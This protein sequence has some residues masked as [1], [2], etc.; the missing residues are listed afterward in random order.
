MRFLDVENNELKTL[1]VVAMKLTQLTTLKLAGNPM[2]ELPLELGKLVYLTHI[3]VPANDLGNV[4]RD[5]VQAGGSAIIRY[6]CGINDCATSGLLDLSK[7]NLHVL[8]PS[9]RE[10]RTALTFLKLDDNP[11]ARLPNWLGEM[12][13]LVRVSLSN[14]PLQRLPA[15]LGAIATLEDVAVDGNST[16][17][18]S[19]PV[20]VVA[21]GKAAVLSY[22]RRAYSAVIHRQLDLGGFG[23]TQFPLLALSTPT[24]LTALALNDNQLQEVPEALASITGLVMLSLANNRIMALPPRTFLAMPQLKSLNVGGNPLVR[25]PITLGALSQLEYLDFDASTALVSPPRDITVKSVVA[26]VTYL[27]RAWAGRRSGCLEL[28]GLSLSDLP[29]EVTEWAPYIPPPEGLATEE[30]AG[31]VLAVEKKA[32]T[33]SKKDRDSTPRALADDAPT[34]VQGQGAGGALSSAA[35]DENDQEQD[36]GEGSPQEEEEGREAAYAV[37]DAE[38]RQEQ[39]E[40]RTEAM[41]AEH[42]LAGEDAA[43]DGDRYENEDDDDRD[44]EAEEDIPATA[45]LR[46][47][48]DVGGVEDAEAEAVV[49]ELVSSDEEDLGAAWDDDEAE[50]AEGSALLEENEVP[51]LRPLRKLDLRDNTLA[52]LREEVGRMQSLRAVHLCRNEIKALPD[53]LA[54]LRNLRVLVA[55]DNQISRVPDDLGALAHSLQLLDLQFN[56]LVEFPQAIARLSLLQELNLSH[57][58]LLLVKLEDPSFAAL[59]ALRYLYLDHN[60]LLA[61]SAGVSSLPAEAGVD[62]GGHALSL[63]SLRVL[64]AVDNQVATWPDFTQAKRLHTMRLSKNCLTKIGDSIANLRLLRLLDISNNQLRDIPA[65]LSGAVRLRELM[66]HGNPLDSAP[67]CAKDA[68]TTGIFTFLTA[69]NLAIQSGKA[70]FRGHNLGSIPMQLL[71][72][73]HLH[74]VDLAFNSLSGSIPRYISMLTNLQ[75]LNLADNALTNV[76]IELSHCPKLHTLNLDRNRFKDVVPCICAISQLEVLTMAE[77]DIVTLPPDMANMVSLVMVDLRANEHLS[78][79][80][81]ALLSQNISRLMVYLRTIQSGLIYENMNLSRRGLTDFP[82]DVHCGNG[83]LKT[84]CLAYNEMTSLP[85]SIAELVRLTELDVSNNMLQLLPQSLGAM[86]HLTSLILNDNELLSLPASFVQLSGLT[87]LA[88]E[89]NPLEN[90]PFAFVEQWTGLTQLSIDTEQPVV[91]PEGAVHS[92]TELMPLEVISQGM[93]KCQEYRLRLQRSRAD[94][95][96]DLSVM[97]LSFMPASVL[98]MPLLTRLN[99]TGNALLTIP[100]GITVLVSM[101]DLGLNDNR[102]STLPAPMAALTKLEMLSAMDNRLVSLAPDIGRLSSL[103]TLNLTNNPDLVCPPPE[104]C[105]QGVGDI[106]SFLN[107]ISSGKTTGSIELSGLNLQLLCLPWQDLQSKLQA[108]VLSR[109]QLAAVPLEVD[110]CTNLTALWLD[111]NTLTG[112]PPSFGKLCALKSL[113]LDLNQLAALPSCVC[114][115]TALERLTL[116]N[117]VLRFLHPRMSELQSLTL[118]SAANNRLTMLPASLATIG[119]LRS[120]TLAG[121]PLAPLPPG[122]RDRRDIDIDVE[123]L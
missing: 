52:D 79:V 51:G 17:L 109:N 68:D 56:R 64:S 91:M 33:E 24:T 19:P 80:A 11:L 54:V 98:R 37:D 3:T 70:T 85:E 75:V 92:T 60:K 88:L 121:N 32:P 18:L 25:L 67:I 119:A 2:S 95:A 6:V 46:Y 87:A 117:N 94:G 90:F 106:L 111:S 110:T 84:L 104:V 36:G 41:R 66:L 55:T 77:N 28:N 34:Q 44:F 108:L 39:K 22:L 83:T 45:T 13:Q 86:T 31:E 72:V 73:T 71:E 96:L 15:T 82:I 1:P 43:V 114:E 69:L 112:L 74:E 14:T 123:M 105:S 116:D 118:L 89:R 62:G 120:L 48:E 42:V 76:P 65:A 61:I 38:G 9:V 29:L 40:E 50:S 49:E 30:G 47:M 5:V 93:S 99:L 20:E 97:Q 103:V 10:L 78:P 23:L 113:A 7:M 4:P 101:R 57:N 63:A 115:L 122:L 58:A 8:P 59:P 35:H 27:Q 53:T 81:A 16:T 12:Q 107:K 21:A 26:V 102:L 100:D